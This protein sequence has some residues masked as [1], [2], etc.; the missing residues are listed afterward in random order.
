MGEGVAELEDDVAESCLF[1]Y[2]SLGV[3]LPGVGVLH[4]NDALLK[5]FDLAFEGA[6]LTHVL[7]RGD[8]L[9]IIR[10]FADPDID[11]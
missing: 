6:S 2:L 11:A 3:D 1:K 8:P 4:A 10:S 9:T 7:A 5:A